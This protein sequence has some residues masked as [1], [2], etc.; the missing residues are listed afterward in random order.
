MKYQLFEVLLSSLWSCNYAWPQLLH[1][2]TI[3]TIMRC[4]LVGKRKSGYL[5]SWDP[6]TVLKDML[7]SVTN[8]IQGT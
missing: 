3:N 2:K 5:K 8:W 6:L 1:D 7:K 4:V